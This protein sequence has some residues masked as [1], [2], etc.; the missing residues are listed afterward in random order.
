MA[1][2]HAVAVLAVQRVIIKAQRPHALLFID[3]GLL[4]SLAVHEDAGD[5]LGAALAVATV[6]GLATRVQDRTGW[7]ERIQG[8]K[9]P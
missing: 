6:S 3:H 7:R 2:E 1:A 5:E 8:A 9:P 4:S